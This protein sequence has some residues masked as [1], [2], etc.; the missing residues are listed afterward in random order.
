MQ[1]AGKVIKRTFAAGSKSEHE[2]VFLVTDAGE[3]LLRRQGGNPFYDAD[4]ERFVGKKV[5]CHGNILGDYTFLAS[6][7]EEI[8]NN[9]D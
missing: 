4:L 2:G 1:Q 9:Q 5:V 3:F 7:F 8:K 6:S